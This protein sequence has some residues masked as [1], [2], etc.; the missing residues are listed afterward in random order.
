MP[1][2]EK[3]PARS[4]TIAA[5][6]VVVVGGLG[7]SAHRVLQTARDLRRTTAVENAARYSEALQAFRSVYTSEVVQRAAESGG[8]LYSGQFRAPDRLEGPELEI[9]FVE[10]ETPAQC[11]GLGSCRGGPGD[12]PPA[13]HVDLGGCQLLAVLSR[14]H[15]ARGHTLDQQ[16]RLGFARHDRR[17]R[18]ASGDQ[19]SPQPQIQICLELSGLAVALEAV[20]LED[21][22]DVPFERQ[23]RRGRRG[24]GRDQ[25]EQECG[26]CQ[27]S[28]R[29]NPKQESEGGG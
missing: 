4:W 7:L 25:A 1:I 23:P 26:E 3:Y 19:E 2:S 24:E 6:T 20:C 18:F 12:D 14:R 8:L 21:A 5:F 9:A 11:L 10:L 29:G 17:T 27:E 16:A 13:E 28:H 15:L 22:T